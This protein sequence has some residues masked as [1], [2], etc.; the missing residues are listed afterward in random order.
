[1]FDLNFCCSRFRSFIPP[2]LFRFCYSCAIQHFSNAP[3]LRASYLSY[4][5][6]AALPN[7]RCITVS[8]PYGCAWDKWSQF[9]MSAL[10]AAMVLQI[11][12]LLY[13]RPSKL[14]GYGFCLFLFDH[15]HPLAG[16][17]FAWFAFS[18]TSFAVH[19]KERDGSRKV[20][21]WP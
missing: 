17:R 21:C 16:T 11:R 12:R 2:L 5:Q 1:M 20:L 10:F 9:N 13:P 15:R 14:F 19:I 18:I 7:R 8:V 6:S 4:R 3:V